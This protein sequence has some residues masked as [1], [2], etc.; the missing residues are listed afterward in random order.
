M[1]CHRRCASKITH[2][3]RS[4]GKCASYNSYL[5]HPHSNDDAESSNISL[6]IIREYKV[7]PHCVGKTNPN[8]I[9]TAKDV[10]RVPMSAAFCIQRL[11]D[12][13][14]N[15]DGNRQWTGDV[16]VPY[17]VISSKRK[18]SLLNTGT[19]AHLVRRARALKRIRTREGKAGYKSCLPR[20]P[21]SASLPPSSSWLLFYLDHVCSR[22]RS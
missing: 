7:D 14:Q 16:L 6:G 19:Q 20:C 21:C 2:L 8:A 12:V 18:C 5:R 4:R 3:K 1:L 17:I 15:G 13:T 9:S 10:S 22:G 11:D